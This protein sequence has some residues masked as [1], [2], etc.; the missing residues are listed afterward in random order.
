MMTSLLIYAVLALAPIQK[1][2]PQLSVAPGLKIGC[3]IVQLGD[4]AYKGYWH[5]D[6]YQQYRGK[7]VDSEYL[8]FFKTS[9]QAW[10]ACTK[11]RQAVGKRLS[12]H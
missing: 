10:A 2:R 1:A 4:G 7:I 6:G 11:Y 8:G 5:V 12:K 3:T 9:K